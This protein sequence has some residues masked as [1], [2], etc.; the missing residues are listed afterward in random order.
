[1]KE[2]GET[3][4]I[5]IRF[6][7]GKEAPKEEV[8]Q[9]APRFQLH[10]LHWGCNS[11]EP[12]VGGF[13]GTQHALRELFF[14][15]YPPYHNLL[16]DVAVTQ[17][18]YCVGGNQFTVETFLKQQQQQGSVPHVVWMPSRYDM[19]MALDYHL[20]FGFVGSGDDSDGMRALKENYCALKEAWSRVKVFEFGYKFPHGRAMFIG[21]ARY[22]DA[23]E[24]V[25]LVGVTRYVG[26]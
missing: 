10:T 6:G 9:D 22:L 24:V 8:G 1:M 4:T 21:L 11:D 15:L 3:T 13:L 5:G 14:D 2:E 17:R 26:M 7:P 23:V 20:D 19:R 25:D 12:G 18:I 16:K